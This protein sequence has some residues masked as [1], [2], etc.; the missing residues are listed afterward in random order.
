[1]KEIKEIAGFIRDELESAE[2]FAWEAAKHKAEKPEI[3]SV[4]Q[5]MATSKMENAEVLYKHG[6]N[7]LEEMKR[8]GD[9]DMHACHAIWEFAHEGMLKEMADV[10]HMLE[11]YNK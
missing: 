9:P 11:V 5:R 8:R 4:Y 3:S 7:M 10:K 6:N 2:E 1:M